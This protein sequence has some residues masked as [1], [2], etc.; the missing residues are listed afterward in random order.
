MSVRIMF[1]FFVIVSQINM[2]PGSS[3]FATEL[4]YKEEYILYVSKD[5][6]TSEIKDRIEIRVTKKGA[7]FNWF[8]KRE[9][10][11]GDTHT[12]RIDFQKETLIPVSYTRVIKTKDATEHIKLHIN[13]DKIQAEITDSKGDVTKHSIEKPNGTFIIEPFFKRYLALQAGKGVTSGKC[14]I[15]TLLNG[16]LMNFNFEWEIAGQEKITTPAGPFDCFKVKVAPS[17]WF[18]K[19]II[20]SSEAWFDSTGTHK[21]VCSLGKRSR[22]DD[23]GLTELVEYKLIP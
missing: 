1:Y 10:L 19:S 8:E 21:V 13:K 22:F 9:L 17:N 7:H 15:V 11:N 5:V 4:D 3:A 14:P 12:F 23:V 18:I 20:A 16:K 2:I 6:K